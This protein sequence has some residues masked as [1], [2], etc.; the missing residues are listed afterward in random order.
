MH[1]R[2]SLKTVNDELARRG[3]NALLAKGS[4]YFYFQAG[5]AAGWLDRTVKVRA[6]HSL[7][8]K[9]WVQEFRRLKELN[10][11]ILRTAKAGCRAQAGKREEP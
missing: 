10:E 9:Q 2:L 11:R 4:G 3:H 5:E 1:V 6:I 8:L 7:T